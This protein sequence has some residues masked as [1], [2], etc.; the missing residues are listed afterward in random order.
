M[1]VFH[2]N[3]IKNIDIF[4]IFIL[5]FIFLWR[6]PLDS[7]NQTLQS[8]RNRRVTNFIGIIKAFDQSFSGDVVDISTLVDYYFVNVTDIVWQI[9]QIQL[10]AKNVQIAHVQ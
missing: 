6:F 1:V 10:Q 3:A 9:G 8:H 4:F 5:I 2:S 7:F